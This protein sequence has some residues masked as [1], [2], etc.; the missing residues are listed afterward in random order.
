[1]DVKLTTCTPANSPSQFRKRCASSFSHVPH[2]LSHLADP[3]ARS[4]QYFQPDTNVMRLLSEDEWR[5]IGIVRRRR[6]PPGLAAGPCRMG[7][8]SADLLDHG[9]LTDP[10]A[11][12]GALRGARA[13]ASCRASPLSSLFPFSSS[14]HL[15][16]LLTLPPSSP[17]A[18]LP[19]R[20][21][22]PDQVRQRT[23]MPPR[24]RRRRSHLSTLLSVSPLPPR[25]PFAFL[26]LT[27]SASVSS[28]LG[29]SRWS[30]P[31]GTPPGPRV[32]TKPC[33]VRAL[34]GRAALVFSF[35]GSSDSS[36]DVQRVRET[37]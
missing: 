23:V 19:A 8:A 2:L 30:P 27:A 14:A 21:G 20:E 5:G 13:R 25:Y 33:A 31:S 28:V 17:A 3:L 9:L 10:I 16:A 12:V 22:L 1:M 7:R 26:S 29:Q 35:L 6:F 34:A 4:L 24:R 37:R 11:R 32:I 15:L 18:P 36:L